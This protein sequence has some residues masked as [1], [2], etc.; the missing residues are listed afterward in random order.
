[1]WKVKLV[2][3]VKVKKI[4]REGYA[5]I[6]KKDKSCSNAPTSCCSNSS[7]RSKEIA[8]RIGYTEEEIG[9]TIVMLS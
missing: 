1:M 9:S 6:A 7:D 2:E 4:V 5:K 8:R 3:E